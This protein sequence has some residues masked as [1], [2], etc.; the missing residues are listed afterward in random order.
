MKS[1][2]RFSKFLAD[3]KTKH[4]QLINCQSDQAQKLYEGIVKEEIENTEQA[5]LEVFGVKNKSSTSNLPRIKEKL[6]DRLVNTLLCLNIEDGSSEILKANIECNKKLAAVNILLSLGERPSAIDLA[7]KT[8]RTAKKF[9]FTDIVL[10]LCEILQKHYALIVGD[11]K[12]M[13]YYTE[14]LNCYLEI[15][16]YELKAKQYYNDLAF[17]VAKSKA[18]NEVLMVK[19]QKYKEELHPHLD[20]IGT[21]HY[22]FNTYNISI[23]Y[24]ESLSAHKN[25]IETCEAANQYFNNL[26]YPPSKA[27]QLQYDFKQVPALIMLQN[28]QAAEK[29]INQLLTITANSGHN[30]LK[31][32]QYKLELGFHSSNPKLVK[33]AIQEARLHLPKSQ[34]LQELWSIYDGYFKFFQAIGRFEKTQERFRL[35]K[36]LNNVPAF[37]KDK[38]GLN[39]NILIIQ[40]LFHLQR[41]QYNKI[42][43]QTDALK[44]YCSRYLRRNDTFRSN[45]F[46]K[47]LLLL[48]ESNFNR[49]ALERKAQ[50]LVQKLSSMPIN[51]AKQDHDLEIVPYETLW[52]AVLE[53]LDR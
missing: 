34:N 38:R 45:C 50:S 39:I 24:Y 6:N 44:R 5:M 9:D 43:D 33:E 41:K 20:R 13:R 52:E 47:M 7:E 29:K 15:K 32:L 30:S 8:I 17:M 4:I 36:F 3:R 35:G 40:V 12:K 37:S 53:L 26:P 42:I 11:A 51:L 49:I 21:Y 2:I 10:S 28:Y 18:K 27:I 31:I 19:A 16:R 25:V 14:S 23:I 46:I 22:C 1:L 48:P